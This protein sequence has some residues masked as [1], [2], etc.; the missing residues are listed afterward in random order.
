MTH[1]ESGNVYGAGENKY[2]QLGFENVKDQKTFMLVPFKTPLKFTRAACGAEFTLGL[3]D[4]GN[5]YS[6]GNPQYGQTGTGSDYEYI[7]GR[8]CMI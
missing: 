4:E 3:T 1:K 2:M 6:W 8:S 5:V 7:A